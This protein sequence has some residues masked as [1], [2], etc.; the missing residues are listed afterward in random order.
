MSTILTIFGLL[1]T[2]GIAIW[3]HLEA[4]KAKKELNSLLESLP[5]QVFNN[6]SRLLESNRENNTELYGMMDSEDPLES[7]YIDLDKDG[8]KEL[9]V[10]YPIGAHGTA[11]QVFGFRDY[12][13]R[14]VGETSTDTPAGFTIEDI[15]NDGKFEI[16]THE[17]STDADLPYVMGFRDE[18]WYRFE[19]DNFV[20]VKRINLYEKKD[21]KKA[22][23][24][25]VK[26]LEG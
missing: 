13:F 20:E 1:L 9:V 19:N 2:S 24:N 12:E 6:V 16:I 15:D 7:S 25:T 5:S 22:R 4:K 3:Q 10:Q 8:I 23:R 21:I 17:V 18:V 14:L 11:L 26:W